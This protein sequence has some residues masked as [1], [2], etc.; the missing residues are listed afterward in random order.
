MKFILFINLTVLALLSCS[1]ENI[2]QTPQQQAT[3]AA[4]AT[5]SQ[6]FYSY[7]LK[8]DG[9]SDD[10]DALQKLLNESETIYLKS[11]TYIINQTISIKAGRKIYGETGT[12]IKAG[13]KMTGTL[14]SNGR[15]FIISNADN[16]MIHQ[17]KF[18]QSD[19]AHQWSNWSNACIFVQD[20]KNT[21]I[22]YSN[23]N[24]HLP[25]ST[26]GM[27]AVWVSGIKSLNTTI[28]NNQI[29][30]LGIKYAENGADATVVEGNTLINAYSNALTA[31]GNHSSDYSTGCRLTN[32]TITN[33][34]RMGI[35]D[36]GKVDGS[37]IDRNRI[38]GTGK[39]P[40]QALDGIG[41]SAV[42]TN[43]KITNNT[44]SD[45]KLYCI[46]V[47]GNYAPTVTGNQM[48]KSAT[49][50]GIILNLTFPVPEKVKTDTYAAISGNKLKGCRI[51]L[52]VFGDYTGYARIQQ[53][54]FTDSQNSGISIE[55]G[56]RTY[57][58][59]IG[60]NRFSYSAPAAQDRFAVFT[61]TKYAPQTANQLI[62][63]SN[64]TITYATSA[65]KGQGVDMGFVIRTDKA[66]ISGNVVQGNN[67]KSAKGV[68][69]YA[70]TA[71]GAKPSGIQFLNN[72][73]YGATT[74][75]SGYVNKVSSGNNF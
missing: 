39:D 14:L 44:I 20:S 53:N 15:Y 72:K 24:F 26:S 65:A 11:G 32:N 66:V 16:V 58:L 64:D 12:V 69:V 18:T 21:V 29:N 70:F 48:D 67:N 75:L 34:G 54:V 22:E 38:T 13:P 31:N 3:V 28:R 61:Y 2:T 57:Q 45:T 60:N 50:T 5:S 41:L 1:K 62:K 42:G 71:Y 46:E 23:F 7:G 59:E 19:A 6:T 36:W 17:L 47:R 33:A 43:T 73:I 49:A 25:Y 51:G 35:E 40:K 52:H 8:G 30:T 37:V 4:A 63:L 68:P 27:E 10:T 74:D 56:A 9:T 55:S